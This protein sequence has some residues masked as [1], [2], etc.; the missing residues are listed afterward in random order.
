MSNV[1]FMEIPEN[2]E[3]GLEFYLP[4]PED[5]T[6]HLCQIDLDYTIEITVH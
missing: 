5:T 1:C 3:Y 6:V 4:Q 2:S